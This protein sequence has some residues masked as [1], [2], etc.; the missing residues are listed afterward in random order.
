MQLYRSHPPGETSVQESRSVDRPRRV[1]IAIPS[2]DI[3]PGPFPELPYHNEYL[4]SQRFLD[5]IFSRNENPDQAVRNQSD[6]RCKLKRCKQ[7]TSSAS[8]P[9]RFTNVF[10]E[11]KGIFSC[12]KRLSPSNADWERMYFCRILRSGGRRTRFG[13]IHA[14]WLTIQ[15]VHPPVTDASL[16]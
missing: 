6:A 12:Y 15:P 11:R 7:R 16:K 2:P 10:H 3:T 14:S 4:V 13:S 1:S 8:I 5:C 9:S